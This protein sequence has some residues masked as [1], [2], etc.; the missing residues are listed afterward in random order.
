M[1][2]LGDS[3]DDLKNI[4]NEPANFGEVTLEET[5]NHL[6][7]EQPSNAATLLDGRYECKFVSP[8]IINLP[9]CH[10]SKH[11]ISLLSKGLKFI[12]T[13]KHINKARIKEE[14]ETYGRKRRL[15]WH[16]RNEEQEIIINPFMKKSKFNTK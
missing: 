8:N 13:L 5:H 10:L 11:E 12:P 6:F 4:S 2:T 1:V 7:L 3:F 16:Y 9:K 15:M 14:L